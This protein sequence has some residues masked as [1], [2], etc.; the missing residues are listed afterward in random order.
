VSARTDKPQ[1]G[2]LVGNCMKIEIRDTGPGIDPGIA[3]RI[4]D[5]YFSTKDTFDSSGMGLAM[6]HGIVLN[7]G[8]TID[9]HSEPGKGALFTIRFPIVESKPV[10]RSEA[11]EGM[12]GGGGHILFVDDEPAI[13]KMAKSLLERMGY[14]VEAYRDPQKALERLQ[15]KPDIFDLV[16]TD[17]TMPQMSGVQLSEKIKA[18]RPQL[19]VIICTG[20][21]PLIDEDRARQL[22]ISA[23]VMKPLDR[24]TIAKTIH[25]VLKAK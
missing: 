22:G 1:P 10:V 18:I 13:V 17:M 15:A 21:S 2:L 14:R 5:P 25:K 20:H 4:F 7:H 23:Y 8:G 3:D 11:W 9:V 24:E 12:P 19:P 6:V 16:M